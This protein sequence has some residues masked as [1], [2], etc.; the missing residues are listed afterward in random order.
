LKTIGLTGG[1]GSGK[2][3]VAKMLAEL[4]AEVIDADLVGHDIYRPGTLGFDRVTEAFGRDIVGADGSI[5]RKKLG[6]IVFADPSA[7]KRLTAIVHPLIGEVV[8]RRIAARRAAGS[9]QPVVV[10]AA[11]LIEANWT[12][13]VDEVWLVTAPEDLVIERVRIRG[14]A[15]EQVQARIRAQLS[16]DERR[17]HA[18][19]VIDNS[20]DLAAL[21]A[22]VEEAWHRLE[23]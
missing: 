20:G 22:R 15:P 13:L 14:L 3:T 18:S 7:L 10:E 6:A 8:Q 12:P 16:N 9:A 11:V 2:S 5:D 4:G 17:R 23:C 1:I 21:R 19:V